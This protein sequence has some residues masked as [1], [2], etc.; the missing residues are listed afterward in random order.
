LR[1]SPYI[2]IYSYGCI[3]KFTPMKHTLLVAVLLFA[4]SVNGQRFDFRHYEVENGLSNNTV[5]CATQGRDGFMWFGTKHG[6]NRFDGYYFKT[7]SLP[8]SDSAL[9]SRDLIFTLAADSTGTLW[10][11][12]EKGLY[13]Y[14]K[15]QEA[16]VPFMDSL[17][18][19]HDI[20][21]NSKGEL[22]FLSAGRIHRHNLKTN[23]HKAYSPPD[24]F[25]A[26]SISET[27]KGEMWFS[28]TDGY[29]RCLDES[30]GTFAKYSLFGRDT[31]VPLRR[32]SKIM[33]DKQ[34]TLFAGTESQGI[35]AFNLS[36]RSYKD[37]LTHNE[38]G[39]AIHVRDIIK[40]NANELWLA[41]E[42]GIFILNTGTGQ[43]QNIKKK[44]L[45][46]YSLSDNAVYALHKDREG[47]IWAGTFFGGLNYLPNLTFGFEKYYPDYSANS[48]SGSAVREICEDKFGNLWIGSEDAGISR[49]NPVTREVKR[50]LPDGKHTS[51]SNSNIHALLPVN[52]QLW[53]GTFEH[54]LNIMDVSAGQVIKHY[55]AHESENS[56]PSDFVICLM[57]TAKG[58]IYAGTSHG[59]FL[60]NKETDGFS[61]EKKIPS[62][63]FIP[64]VMEDS[65]GRIWAVS[66]NAGVY[67]FDSR[68]K[69]FICSEAGKIHGLPNNCVNSIFEDSFHRL[70]FS[71][72]GGGL[73]KLDSNQ[74]Q[75]TRYTTREGLPSN[76]V[77]KVLEDDRKNLWI[78][79]SKGL[80]CM[81]PDRRM[82]TFTKADGLLT[83]QFNYSSGYKDKNGKLYFGSVR[84]LISFDPKI[85]A[86]QKYTPR[87]FITGMEVHYN[88]L[89]IDRAGS[90]KQSLLYT[91]RI[92]L[93]HDQSSLSFDFAAVS[94]TAPE[95]TSY[96][97]RL[98]GLD[99]AWVSLES[100]RKV[101]FTKL[102]AGNYT[103]QVE[104]LAHAF[105]S[106]Q[107][108]LHI[109]I[110]PPVW[111]TLWAYLIYIALAGS[112]LTYIIYLYHKIQENKKAKA[113][114]DAK[115]EFFTNITHEIRTP[116]T[117]IKGPI[118]NLLRM[119]TELPQISEDVLTMDR[120][121][122]R[123]INLVNQILDFRKAEA[124]GFSLDFREV[125]LTELLKETFL[126]FEPPAKRKGLEYVL[127]LP[128]R[129]VY[130]AAD[131]EALTKILSNLVNNAVKFA[132][133]NVAVVLRESAK[134]ENIVIE[135]KNDGG[136]IS[137]KW[138]EKVFEPF[139]QIKETIRQGSG[140]GLA[141]ARSL[142]ELHQ[143]KLY[144]DIPS[145]NMNIFILELPAA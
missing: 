5:F 50:F 67:Y 46:P 13:R 123:L 113:I 94:F 97:Y 77:Y 107:K 60:Y 38:N 40:S 87:L 99:T 78:T 30:H 24:F 57:Q 68:E 34:G 29:L 121:S 92:T 126:T 141:L 124:K 1:Y 20:Y 15:R 116:L 109:T 48:I 105:Q 53:I 51:I 80:V 7:F 74:K 69:G 110:L 119:K 37:L 122:T 143:G 86:P 16:L 66:H 64:F 85:L 17:K 101:Y 144:L 81:S 22:W 65:R 89:K 83:D 128:A 59:L 112:V 26:T 95:K 118:D 21:V 54:G 47:G 43:F 2:N 6:L 140:M 132:E 52:N 19:I 139:F 75:F 133:K 102:A 130:L 134:K 71:T 31:P 10:A 98:Q 3:F 9:L 61:P 56:L 12:S 42:S 82:K 90:L 91:D 58:R 96:R 135:V 8:G 45:D 49:L 114:F 41:T 93:P 127:Q 11:G 125:N 108:N 35:K 62:G 72:D 131:A 104:A 55:R 84:G 28:S 23:E 27:E 100:K 70:W 142:A 145:D 106:Q 115:I 63:G 129:P 36:K 39:T 79:T 73:C 25:H 32:I 44:F 120:N 136:I 4:V 117:L 33:A 76:L 103:L 137:N 88:E 138:R 14:D 18:I 111:A